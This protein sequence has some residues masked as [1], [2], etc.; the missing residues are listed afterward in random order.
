MKEF[1][2]QYRVVGTSAL[3]TDASLSQAQGSI[4]KFPSTPSSRSRRTA[5]AHAA[6]LR[7]DSVSFRQDLRTGSARGKAFGRIAPW[8]AA[9]A[10]V[11][12]SAAALITIFFGV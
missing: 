7:T 5:P 11:V 6:H 4:I 12:L 2:A 10:G 8:Q 3:K 9:S 1:E